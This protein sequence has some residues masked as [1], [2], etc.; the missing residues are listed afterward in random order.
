MR[1]LSVLVLLI[2]T[3]VW[4]GGCQ[5]ANNNTNKPP[6][7]NPPAND[8]PGNQPP[9]PPMAPLPADYY[10]LTVGSF[11]EYEGSGNEY[12]SF[13]RKVLFAKGGLAQTSED[14][15]GT[16]A[17]RV[18]DSTASYVKVVFMQGED[19]QPQNLLEKGFTANSDDI[20]LQAPIQVGTS[21]SSPN[22][23]VKQI[24]DVNF[25]VT[26]PAG[27]FDNCVQVKQPGQDFTIYQYYQKGV[28]MVKQEFITA[29]N[30]IISSTLK[31][32]EIK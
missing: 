31:R 27:R 3:L 17:T 20:L 30:E 28:G 15:G 1:K 10:P 8:L 18:V 24:V 9:S 23:T 29:D 13:S 5:S 21:W 32:Y 19:Y 2:F 14:N 6:M 12:A 22:N 16:V 4:L 7:N 26:T 25:T 11:W